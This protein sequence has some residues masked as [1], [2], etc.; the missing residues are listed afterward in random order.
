M[1]SWIR[2]Q[3]ASFLIASV[4]T[5]T[6]CGGSDSEAGSVTIVP[7]PVGSSPTPSATPPPS[8]SASPSQAEAMR[9]NFAVAAQAASAHD[10]GFTGRG[11]KVAV[12]DTGV[13]AGLTEFQ[14][15]IDPASRDLRGERG[16][17]DANGHGTSVSAIVAAARDGRAIHGIAYEAT[18]ISFN[19][20]TPG[21]SLM[22]CEISEDATL[23]GLDAAIAAGA[24]IV[25]MSLGSDEVSAEFLAA[26][27]RLAAANIVLI[28]SAGNGSKAEPR[29]GAQSIVQAAPDHVIIVGGHDLAGRPYSRGNRAGAGLAGTRYLVALGEDVSVID[30]T[31]ALVTAHGTSMAAAVVSG[32]AALV[33]QARPKLTASEVTK[34]LLANATDIGAPG[35]DEVFG[36]GML[37]IAATFSALSNLP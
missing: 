34:L 18:L 3:K 23:R 8:P 36:N 28:V 29:A 22:L 12:I 27:R 25:N 5:A 33:L 19:S 4:L 14:P 21:C 17:I 35:R 10:A 13:N 30:S 15:R 1:Q 16:I 24:R 31:G 2:R 9:S 20:S 37:N 6:G 32:A 11:I 7:V 26:V